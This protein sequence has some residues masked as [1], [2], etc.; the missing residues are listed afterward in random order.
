[1]ST[2]IYANARFCFREDT[3]KNWTE[4]NPILEKGE[5]A[6]VCDGQNGEWLKIGDGATDF[7]NLP[8]KTGPKGDKGEQGIQGEKGETG[9]NGKDAVTDQTYNPNSPN[10]QSGVAVAQALSGKLD[11]QKNYE[12]IATIKV[13]PDV[14]GNL[15]TSLS[16]T[17]DSNGNPFELTDF[18]L[19]MVL[20]VTDGSG[21]KIRF[22][23]NEK[24]VFGNANPSLNTTLRSWYI[25]YMDLGSGKL[26]IAPNFSVGWPDH[27]DSGNGYVTGFNG[28]ILLPTFTGYDPVKRVN[29][30]I[31]EGATK[32]F[33]EGSEFKLY[34]VRK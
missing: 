9:A 21:A 16:F 30:M 24:L 3:L 31:M 4:I 15:P 1:M 6:V 18:Y 19:S 32:T 13:A 10:A 5:P 17:E 14:D 27:L 28:N 26:C 33:I 8:W 20:G 25:N 23:V 29:I 7:N 34:G 12:L 2:K 11:K 22:N